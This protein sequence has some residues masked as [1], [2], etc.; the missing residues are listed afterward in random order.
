MDNFI[1]GAISGTVG[2]SLSHPFDT[3]KSNLQN[4][5]KIKY[6]IRFLYRGFTPPLIGVGIEKSIVLGVYNNSY[7]YLSK[8]KI[9]E[10]I[11]N[12]L[13]GSLAGLSASIVVTP[14]EKIK[15]MLQTGNTKNIVKSRMLFQGISATFTR[16][17][18]GFTLYFNIYEGMKYLFC[19]DKITSLNSFIFGRIAG[20][21]SWIFIYPQDCIKTR[22]QA[23]NKKITFFQTM[24]KIYLEGGV[25]NFYKGFHF[26]ILRAFPLHAGT[27]MTM[28]LLKKD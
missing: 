9:N 18:P 17:I 8:Y 1:N 21:A 19:K 23:S 13:C 14:I 6:N 26:A 5:T 15:I 20:S 28:E 12:S 25:K 4:G 10:K 16:E 24:K 2:I 27:F 11:K 3:I 7:N 22:M